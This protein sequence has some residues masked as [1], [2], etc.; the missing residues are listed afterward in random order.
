MPF[1]KR[2]MRHGSA[3][4]APARRT[5]IAPIFDLEDTNQ[6]SALVMAPLQGPNTAAG[7]LGM[8]RTYSQTA[9]I[10]LQLRL[11]PV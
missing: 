9:V 7:T 4:S 5:N 11:T 10:K 2:K 1:A 6:H 3:Q 8:R